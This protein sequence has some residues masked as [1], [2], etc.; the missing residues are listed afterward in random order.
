[1]PQSRGE[2]SLN[3]ELLHGLGNL[4]LVPTWVNSSLSDKEWSRKRRL[5]ELMAEKSEID[6]RQF[7][8]RLVNEE[9]LER[10]DRASLERINNEGV[11]Q[12]IAKSLAALPGE[13]DSEGIRSRG[14]NILQRAHAR[15]CTWL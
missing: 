8:D 10:S 11:F 1:M 5:F 9:L 7:V 15:L 13:L 14:K 12:D 4:T 2:G 6:A 3:P